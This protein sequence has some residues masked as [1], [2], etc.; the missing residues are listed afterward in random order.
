MPNPYPTE[1]RARAVR[2]YESG[3]ET[4]ATVA[5]D[6]SV[7]EPT[8]QRWVRR[9]RTTGTVDPLVKA[10]GWTSRS[11]WPCC[12]RPLPRAPIARPTN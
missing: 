6:F 9:Q 4:Y 10:G 12:R 2:A 11:M 5:S 7:S 8:L 3:S 1:L